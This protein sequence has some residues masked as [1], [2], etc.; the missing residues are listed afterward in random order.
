MKSWKRFAAIAAFLMI[1]AAAQT[2]AKPAPAPKSKP[3]AKS[4]SPTANTLPAGAERI[5]EY[6]WKHK[7]A[8]G[9]TWVYVQTPFGFS[10]VDEETYLRQQAEKQAD[11]STG[12]AMIRVV[13]Q[14]ADKVT[15]EIMTPLGK[16]RWQKPRAEL[17]EKE[18]AALEQA[19]AAAPK[20]QE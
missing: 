14:D 12:S 4:S 9:K 3:A 5:G 17:G 10:K 1:P 15:F 6:K 8:A 19:N 7:D 2:A 18:K 16:Q 11:T 13:E 20:P